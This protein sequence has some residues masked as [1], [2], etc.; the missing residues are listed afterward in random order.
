MPSVIAPKLV[1]GA[2][3]LA[4]ACTGVTPPPAPT[5]SIDVDGVFT[6]TANLD[7]GVID[8]QQVSIVIQAAVVYLVFEPLLTFDVVT[9]RPAAGAAELPTISADGMTYRFT[10]RPNLTY[11]DGQPVKAYDFAY[12]ISRIHAGK[13][14]TRDEY[15]PHADFAF[16]ISRRVL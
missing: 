15:P 3:L 16:G 12:G 10:L 11:S 13:G 4:A 6:Q 2:A 9:L 1:V 7:P 8:P 5:D 14:L